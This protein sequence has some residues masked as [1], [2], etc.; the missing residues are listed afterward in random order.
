MA[1]SCAQWSPKHASEKNA[2]DRSYMNEM[3]R[4]EHHVCGGSSL[5]EFSAALDRCKDFFNV[6]GFRSFKL[7]CDNTPL[8]ETC[9]VLQVP[10]L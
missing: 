6:L 4:Y 5:F 2:S 7:L 10:E 8:T 3:L 9:P 1:G